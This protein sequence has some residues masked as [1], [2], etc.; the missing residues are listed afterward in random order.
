[1]TI[2]T[3]FCELYQSLST[4]LNVFAIFTLWKKQTI[5]EH[6]FILIVAA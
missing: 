6:G 1:L 3:I 4:D 2:L 5:D